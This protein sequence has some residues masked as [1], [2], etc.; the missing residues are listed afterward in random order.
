MACPNGKVWCKGPGGFGNIC[1]DCQKMGVKPPAVGLPK[2]PLPLVKGASPTLP[3]PAVRVKPVVALP[4]PSVPIAT[5]T[6]GTGRSVVLYRG[7][8]REPGVIKQV[9]FERWGESIANVSK[10]GGLANYIAGKCKE[11]KN[12]K[13]FADFVRVSKNQGRPTI[14][15][16][17]NQGCGGY[18]SGP[19]Y[20]I[21]V[22]GLQEYELN[23]KIMPPSF[24]GMTWSSDGLKV[25]M[26]GN[27]LSTSH[28]VVIDLRLGTE[29]WAFF[30]NVGSQRITEYKAGKAAFLSMSTVTPVV[31][32]LW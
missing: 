8:S 6:V 16:S 24:H 11:L 25:Y 26:N 17:L 5:E 29:E 7:D 28:T 9:G 23:E 18:D 30:T 21:E 32:K 31:K 10:V 27:S 14:S 4:T 13:T 12:G 22:G 20:K 19:I 15:T 3:T 2:P 1:Q